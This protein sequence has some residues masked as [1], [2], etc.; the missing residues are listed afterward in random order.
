MTLAARRFLAQK[1][2][3][4]GGGGLGGRAGGGRLRGHGGRAYHVTRGAANK[5][6]LNDNGNGVVW[7]G[8]KLLS[9][10]VTDG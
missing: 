4:G 6:F 3:R 9:E 8:I 5:L 1:L 10:S 7:S 2:V